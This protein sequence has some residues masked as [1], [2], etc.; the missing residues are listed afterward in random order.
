[1][2]SWPVISFGLPVAM[3]TGRLIIESSTKLSSHATS[4]L[5][6]TSV[7]LVLLTAQVT[8]LHLRRR[9]LRRL[10]SRRASTS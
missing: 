9:R 7:L 4:V 6:G 3:T 10:A 2:L 1:V 5:V 8:M